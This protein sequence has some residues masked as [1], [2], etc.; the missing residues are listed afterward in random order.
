MTSYKAEEKMDEQEMAN[1]RREETTLKVS[2]DCCSDTD[3]LS[4]ASDDDSWTDLLI[5]HVTISSPLERIL[6]QLIESRIWHSITVQGCCGALDALLSNTPHSTKELNIQGCQKDSL[7]SAFP[8]LGM[9][10]R[11]SKSIQSITLQY[12]EFTNPMMLAL[13]HGWG[14]IPNVHV[15]SCTFPS[16]LVK[17]SFL[18][19]LQR[20]ATLQRLDVSH[21]AFESPF[22]QRILSSLV[23]KHAVKEIILQHNCIRTSALEALEKLL[24]DPNCSIERL[25][26]GFQHCYDSWS[27]QPILKALTVNRSLQILDISCNILIDSEL[28]A[29]AALMSSSAPCSTSLRQVYLCTTAGAQ[30]LED[31]NARRMVPVNEGTINAFLKAARQNHNLVDIQLTVDAKK[32]SHLVLQ[33]DLYYQCMENKVGSK[34]MVTEIYNEEEK[35]PTET[36]DLPGWLDRLSHHCSVSAQNNYTTVVSEQTEVHTTLLYSMIQQSPT[37]L[38]SSPSP[39]AN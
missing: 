31:I 21:N 39:R 6:L 11:H 13:T 34:Q 22:L 1:S 5:D 24:M 37:I 9:A 28:Q 12:M 8:L 29:L 20:H 30:Q 3:F 14:Q 33:R 25:D 32:P 15:K 10:L 7:H 36:Y 19:G 4:L 27:F 16:D 23:G 26:L 35:I 17:N 38:L 2:I 18:L